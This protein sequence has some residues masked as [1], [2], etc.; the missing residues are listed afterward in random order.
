LLLRINISVTGRVQNFY[1]S[2]R[3]KKLLK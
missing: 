2:N 3:K 1:T